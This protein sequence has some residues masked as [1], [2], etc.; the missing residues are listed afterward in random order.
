MSP[1]T[2]AFAKEMAYSPYISEV[3]GDNRENYRR[4][5]VQISAEILKV[6]SEMGTIKN[7]V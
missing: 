4:A 2:E 5:L 6:K 1:D 7:E 3:N